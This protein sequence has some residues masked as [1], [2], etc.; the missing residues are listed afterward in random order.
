[1]SPTHVRAFSLTAS[2]RP[3][4]G[5]VGAASGPHK[6]TP[7]ATTRSSWRPQAAP[8][9]T[10]EAVPAGMMQCYRWCFPP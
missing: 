10:S 1:M 3:C 8:G 5:P 2:R 4:A 9:A 6:V 7:V